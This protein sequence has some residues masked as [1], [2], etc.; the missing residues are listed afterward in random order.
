VQQGYADFARAALAEREDSG[1][2]PYSRIALLRASASR[3]EAAMAFLREM[4]SV[5]ASIA[6]AEVRLLGPVTAPLARR[7]GRYRC[8]LLLQSPERAPLH[9][10][11][12]RLREQA[13]RAP[14]ASRVRWSLDVDPIELF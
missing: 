6:G 8:Q 12:A 3:P 10:L 5:L 13:E 1:W 2:P 7:A 9:R 4:K 11:L 14:G